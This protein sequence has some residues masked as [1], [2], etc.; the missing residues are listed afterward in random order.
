M[1]EKAADFV[2]KVLLTEEKPSLLHCSKMHHSTENSFCNAPCVCVCV[3]TENSFSV[4]V[5]N[6]MLM[7]G[8]FFF[9]CLFSVFCFFF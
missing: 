7:V 3:V 4:F 9:V 5:L 1:W 8:V 6:H 2:N